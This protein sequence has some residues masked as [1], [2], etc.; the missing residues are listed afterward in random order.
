MVSFRLDDDLSGA[1]QRIGGKWKIE[2]SE[3]IRRALSHV[4][5]LYD[6]QTATFAS[7]A[8]EADEVIGMTNKALT[9]YLHRVNDEI[10]RPSAGA[11][12]EAVELLLSD[13]H[14]LL[15][16]AYRATGPHL[17]GDPENSHYRCAMR[18]LTDAEIH[19]RT[20][21]REL[22]PAAGSDEPGPVR[23]D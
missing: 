4:V 16:N 15:G 5:R 17:E 6:S 13:V 9:G 11:I 3:V 1:L 22:A 23:E 2:R 19:L 7:A 12:V 20:A 8:E 14:A 18:S 10:D 21:L